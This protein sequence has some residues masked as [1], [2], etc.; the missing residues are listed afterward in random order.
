MS[1]VAQLMP[2]PKTFQERFGML[3]ILRCSNCMRHSDLFAIHKLGGP[4]L[5]SLEVSCTAA[6]TRT[7]LKTITHWP[8]WIKQ[9]TFAHNE[10]LALDHLRAPGQQMLSQAKLCPDNWDTQPIVLNLRDA[11]EGFPFS[12]SWREG[13]AFVNNKLLVLNRNQPINPGCDFLKNFKCLQKLIYNEHMQCKF[14]LDLTSHMQNRLDDMFHPY[15]VPWHTLQF[16]QALACVKALHPGN[17][18][19]IIKT[20]LNGWHTSS[21]CQAARIHPCLFGCDGKS[22]NLHHYIICP[23]LFR[24]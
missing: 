15:T 4:K 8:D 21:R 14:N 13:G 3:S 6:L 20:W 22:D 19:K 17:A 5:R 1:Y 11:Y 9:L 12:K 18:L 10:F 23:N 16:S 2:L 24:L 7:A